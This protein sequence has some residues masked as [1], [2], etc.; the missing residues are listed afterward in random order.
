MLAINDAIVILG[1]LFGGDAPLAC[2]NAADADDDGSVRINDPIAILARLFQ[3]AAPLPPPGPDCGVDV[4][5][6]DLACDS[7]CP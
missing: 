6:D 1:R 4:T 5:P 3:G 7:G 2:Q